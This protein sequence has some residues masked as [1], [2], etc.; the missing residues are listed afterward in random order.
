[1]KR[2]PPWPAAAAG[3]DS[4]TASPAADGKHSRRLIAMM[5]LGAAALDLIP[6]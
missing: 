5:F 6:P 2:G 1:M 3:A 4:E